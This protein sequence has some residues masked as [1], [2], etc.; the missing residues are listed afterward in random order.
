[1]DNDLRKP[2]G[3][4]ISCMSPAGIRC[5][6]SVHKGLSHWGVR[7]RVWEKEKLKVP[8]DAKRRQDPC[9]EL[10]TAKLKRL[11]R[12]R[13]DEDNQTGDCKWINIERREQRLSGKELG[14]RSASCTF[15][16]STP[17]KAKVED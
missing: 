9:G 17:D 14:I 10:T 16:W 11:G 2:K 4:G 13:I 15:S 6:F 5:H 1:M 3:S 12:R 7:G 8:K